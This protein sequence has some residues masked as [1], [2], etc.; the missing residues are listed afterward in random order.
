MAKRERPTTRV[1][2]GTEPERLGSAEWHRESGHLSRFTLEGAGRAIV[3]YAEDASATAILRGVKDLSA[4]VQ[5]LRAENEQLSKKVEDL[6]ERPPPP[7]PATAKKDATTLEHVPLAMIVPFAV[8]PEL[9][10]AAKRDPLVAL[11]VQVSR[12]MQSDASELERA[13]LLAMAA[14]ASRGDL[15]TFWS[16]SRERSRTKLQ[17][18][19]TRARERHR[20][21]T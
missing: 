3:F 20:G 18:N 7:S 14:A 19:V 10:G 16:A 6:E 15:E 8:T 13:R 17:V 5:R 9:R 1:N 21:T 12:A 11:A 4:A 2:V